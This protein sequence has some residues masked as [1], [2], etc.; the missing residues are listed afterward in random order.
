MEKARIGYARKM[1]RKVLEDCRITSP[2]VDL[3][4]IMDRKGYEY[5]EV[6]NFPDKVD[7]LFLKNENDGKTYAAV[8]AGHH[9][10]RQRF[11]LAHEFG[12]LLLNHDLNYYQTYISIDDPP[13]EIRHTA[14]EGA[15]ETE[16]NNFAGELLVPLAML[17]EEF[18]KTN[19][20]KQLSKIF[21]VSQH[22]ASI[23]IKT[24]MTSLYK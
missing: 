8:N 2:P 16:A 24:H 11:S 17:K 21:W 4:V 6:D 23:S 7:A 14:A 22:V 13:S 19:D 3:K 20:L 9:P 15:F 5:I 1:A 18:K 12:H 10:H